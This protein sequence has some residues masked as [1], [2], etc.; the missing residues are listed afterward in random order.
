MMSL[1]YD[2][3]FSSC[4]IANICCLGIMSRYYEVIAAT[5]DFRVE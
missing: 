3:V 4:S 1:S 2:E 5:K